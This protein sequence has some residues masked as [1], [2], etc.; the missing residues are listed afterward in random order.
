M[1]LPSGKTVS[2]IIFGGDRLRAKRYIFLPDHA[3]QRQLYSLL[4]DALELGINTF[5]TARAY[6]QSERILGAWMRERRNRDRVCICTKLA[7]PD[8]R[9]RS[10]L[11]SRE[12]REDFAASLRALGTEYVDVLFVHYDDPKIGVEPVLDELARFVEQGKVGVIG[13]SNWQH[14]RIAAANKYAVQSG[15][16]A[17]SAASVHFGP[18]AWV[19][20]PWPGAWQISGTDNAPARQYYTE[21]QLPV[22]IWSSLAFGFFA[23]SYDPAKPEESFR[24]RRIARLYGSDA[25]HAILNRV[26][27]YAR[28]HGI[29]AAQVA[30]AFNL[31]QR[32][33][34][35]CIVGCSSRARLE[36]CVAALRVQLEPDFVE[37]LTR[38]VISDCRR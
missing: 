9:Q 33:P 4:D 35:H 36:D 23:E 21:T 1:Q 15:K 25:N 38:N 20:S 26:R 14:Q 22:F 32:F 2:R 18:V 17:F 6:G 19:R 10:R 11:S 8:W 37:A 3:K 28:E 27:Q 5:D 7:C 16:A 13:A 24:S 12:I 34:T 31:N 30:L 29:S